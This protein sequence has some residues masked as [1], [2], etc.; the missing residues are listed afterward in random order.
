MLEER[1]ITIRFNVAGYNLDQMDLNDFKNHVQQL[2]KAYTGS[3]D[4]GIASNPSI[5]MNWKEGKVKREKYATLEP[6][7]RS[8][9]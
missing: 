1:E 4:V 2:I 3:K 8:I 6:A 9:K 5:S 7:L